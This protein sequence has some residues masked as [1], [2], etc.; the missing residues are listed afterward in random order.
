V[1]FNVP[2]SAIFF[3][4]KEF[5]KT[6]PTEDLVERNMIAFGCAA[7]EKIATTD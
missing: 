1:G 6:D 4:L 3:I 7:A 2:A 5:S